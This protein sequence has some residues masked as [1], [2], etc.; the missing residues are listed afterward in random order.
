MHGDNARDRRCAPELTRS[1]EDT[2]FVAKL[3]QEA[4]LPLLQILFSTHIDFSLIS[5]RMMDAG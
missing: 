3:L 5:L 1:Q 4:C 2:C